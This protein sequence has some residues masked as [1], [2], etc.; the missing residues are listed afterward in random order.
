MFCSL[1]AGEAVFRC[2]PYSFVIPTGAEVVRAAQ[3]R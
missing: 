3:L 1:E 2:L